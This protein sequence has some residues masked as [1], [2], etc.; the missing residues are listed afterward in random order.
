MD[1]W[2]RTMF[3]CFVLTSGACLLW[4]KRVILAIPIAE[5][6]VFIGACAAGFL[7]VALWMDSGRI[8]VRS[9]SLLLA[10]LASAAG[11]TALAAVPGP[12]RL[13]ALPAAGCVMG[14]TFFHLQLTGL[15]ALPHNRRATGF[16]S[17]F[18]C[19]GA[20]NTTTD[21][22]AVAAL[23]VHGS[24]PNLTMAA[25]S[26]VCAAA[27][28]AFTGQVFDT[29]LV[30]VSSKSLGNTRQ[31]AV[32]ALLAAAGFVL[33]YASLSLQETIVYPE[34]VTRVTSSELIR[35]IELPLFLAAG[36]A[37]DRLG[38][39]P[40]AIAALVG[41]LVG[42][43]A[44]VDPASSTLASAGAFGITCALIAYP[45]ACVA[46][47]VD[48]SCYAQRPALLGCLA[49]APQVVGNL[50]AVQFVPATRDLGG[51][52]QFLIAIAILAAFTAAVM[53]MGELVSKNFTALRSST[54]LVDVSDPPTTEPD[55]TAATD[56]FGLTRREV[57]ILRLSLEGLTV[58][59]MA[60][61]LFVTETTIKFHI[62]NLLRKT[63]TTSRA[64]LALELAN[65]AGQR[66]FTHPASPWTRLR[67]LRTPGS[68]TRLAPDRQ[69][70]PGDGPGQDRLAP[71]AH[72]NAA[73]I[74]TG[75]R[76]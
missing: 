32:I 6:T 55:L 16:A 15:R 68:R 67:T 58:P 66:Q 35:Y 53:V 23:Y 70:T 17:F 62:T 10:G 73:R 40:V 71:G 14:A 47:M 30:P 45:V 76:V 65:P 50:L 49:F 48:A 69:T 36:L 57:E 19:A 56:R 75:R 29:R 24:A 22:P 72:Q 59:R 18:M 9:S 8:R 63:G 34:A 54:L 46:L 5:R 7:A 4:Y 12:V 41:A 2:R 38:R 60:A 1:A 52:T 33:L 74:S 44:L 26:L 43:A 21:M 42:A 64:E 37:A 61:Q 28:V 20:I 25:L 13:V 31:S 27:L 11:L 51:T 39:Q 3:W